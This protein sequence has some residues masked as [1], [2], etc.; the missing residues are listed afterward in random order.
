MVGDGVGADVG[1][2]VRIQADVDLGWVE[3]DVGGA[4]ADGEVVGGYDSGVG[5]GCGGDWWGWS[6][7][8]GRSAGGFWG[9]LCRFRGGGVFDLGEFFRFC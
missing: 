5:A 3:T 4:A 1:Q 2:S 7:V 6:G 9:G 8:V